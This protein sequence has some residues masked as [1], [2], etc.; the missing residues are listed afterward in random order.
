MFEE[1]QPGRNPQHLPQY[2][3]KTPLLR[4]HKVDVSYVLNHF[5]PPSSNKAIT[6]DRTIP[7]AAKI[8]HNVINEYSHSK[9]R[10][11]QRSSGCARERPWMPSCARTQ[12]YDY[13]MLQL[14]KPLAKRLKIHP[15]TE[16]EISNAINNNDFTDNT[17][18]CRPTLSN[19]LKLTA[20]KSL[21]KP[22]ATPTADDHIVRCVRE[23]LHGI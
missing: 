15:S 10:H 12:T 23:Q 5:H 19:S 6:G 17:V 1:E 18:K 22:Q 3:L 4:L 21:C 9:K 20:P 8:T 11:R 13:H 16:N 7:L 14:K 2:R